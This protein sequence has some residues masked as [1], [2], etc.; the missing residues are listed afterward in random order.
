[1][2]E[3]VDDQI[4]VSVKSVMEELI[5][6]VLS[7]VVI[8]PYIC[9][10]ISSLLLE[11]EEQVGYAVQVSDDAL[12]PEG[13]V[14]VQQ[15]ISALWVT[16]ND[17]YQYDWDFGIE[18]LFTATE[19]ANFCNVGISSV[20]GYDGRRWGIEELYVYFDNSKCNLS[21]PQPSRIM[22]AFSRI[23]MLRGVLDALGDDA[24]F[25]LPMA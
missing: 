11:Y 7:G 23:G 12:D 13:N 5:A 16:F 3:V 8:T 20:S 6:G 4:R 21:L 1:M 10:A 17:L 15:I 25:Y 19:L 9:D 24:Y 18:C 2:I 22:R 14:I